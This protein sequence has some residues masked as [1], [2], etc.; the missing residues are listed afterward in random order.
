MYMFS[1]GKRPQ[2]DMGSLLENMQY[3]R[4]DSLDSDSSSDLNNDN[5]SNLS[6]SASF[7]I[8]PTACKPSELRRG[9]GKVAKIVS[10][11]AGI[12]WIISKKNQFESVWFN[13]E[14]TFKYG[15]NLYNKKLDECLKEG[16]HIQERAQ[17]VTSINSATHH[18][19]ICVQ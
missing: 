4:K 9:V 2:V 8:L 3:A 15:F 19:Y 10:D 17:I 18:I 1:A 16:E 5:D 14:K 6:N 11:S 12:I 13:R 7:L